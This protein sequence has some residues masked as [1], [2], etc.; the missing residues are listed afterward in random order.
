[1][2]DVFVDLTDEQVR[3]F[4]E[5]GFLC[6][7]RI[8]TDQELAWLRTV[9]DE[10][11]KQRLGYTLDEPSQMIVR[12]DPEPLVTILSPEK[13]IPELK[14]TIFYRNAREVLA[15]LL[16]VEETRLLTGWRI[17]L[18]LARAGE[19]PWHQDSAYHPPPHHGAGIWMP[20]ES[21]TC[22]SGCLQYIS[23]SQLGDLLPHYL[24][25]DNL[26]APDVDSSQTTVCP[27]SPGEALIHHCR[28]LHYAGPNRTDRARRALAV[29][30]QVMQSGMIRPNST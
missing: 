7:G 23:G 14:S 27:L 2:E 22:E 8:T 17:F 13:V 24:Q 3:C 15:R 9:C 21:A 4:Q 12:V 28:T 1:M 5:R 19:T 26:V 10:V 30:C 25:D 11:V 6:L 20:L 16:D 29:V 18:K